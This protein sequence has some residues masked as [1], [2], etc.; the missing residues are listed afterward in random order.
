MAEL[1]AFRED[2]LGFRFPL[3]E[4]A[5]LG[6]SADCDLI[7]FDRSASRRHAEITCV[8]G[9]H[10]IEDLDSTNGT[11]VNDLPITA[12]TQLKPYDC[13]K[14]GQEIYIFEPYLDVI[15]GSAP[16]ALILNAVNESQQNT[17]SLLVQDSAAQLSQAQ[18]VQLAS[19]SQALCFSP[20]EGVLSALVQ[21]FVER[22]GATSVAA[23]WPSGSKGLKQ[24]SLLSHP[25]D[26]RL[27]LSNVPFRRVTELGQSLIWPHI[28]TE[29]D[30]TAGNRIIDHL[31][32]PCL[33]A[34]LFAQEGRAGLLYVEN[35]NRPLTEAD[36][37]LMSA[38]ALIVSPYIK[39]MLLL[40]ALDD[41]RRLRVDEEGFRANLIGRDNQIKVIYSTAAHLAQSDAPIF[42]TGEVGTGKTSLARHIHQ[43][44]PKRNE[45]FVEVTLSGQSA[46][47]MD[48]ILFGQE[49][50]TETVLGLLALADKGTVFLRHI[51]HMSLNTQRAILMALE[52]GLIYPLGS[53][54]PRSI[55]T[56]FVT[57][58]SANLEELVD[59]G[60]FREDL[61]A[62]L[63][64][65]NLALPPL[66]ET[67]NDIEGL[68]TYYLAKEARHL[69]LRFRG[70]DQSSAE[71]LRAYPWPGNLNE[72]KNLA[73]SLAQFSHGGQVVVDSLPVHIRLAPEVFNHEEVPSDSLL[74]EAERRFASKALAAHAGDVEGACAALG[75]PPD[76]FIK[77]I[78]HYGL[79]PLDFQE[80]V[81]PALTMTPGN[82]SL[83]DD[84]D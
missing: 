4:R 19:F 12:R 78:R 18:I 1:V 26:K 10:Y 73:A 60:L 41:D 64:K 65:L 81:A 76:E 61:Y 15:V 43:Q 36:L 23:L 79:D 83:P 6:R 57:S 38:I 66:R 55:S 9:E 22:L 31:D 48:Q 63:T 21:F 40:A 54:Q 58:S 68:M 35:S 52:E 2:R 47:Q 39:S 62:R 72:L 67:R 46:A 13:L 11:L 50:G 71:C 29:L 25:H 45:R 14:I 82:T 30:F 16:A 32:Q 77:K 28:I 37:S 80:S 20:P 17:V 42:L 33:L 75:L 56:R 70:L 44:S 27:L 69:G 51:E 53:T 49:S 74:A 8:D 3:P 7:L 5:L 34:P 59:Q 24:M 84:E